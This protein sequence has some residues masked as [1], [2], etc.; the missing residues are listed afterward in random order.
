MLSTRYY[1]DKSSTPQMLGA[2]AEVLRTV[3]LA[4]SIH[5]VSSHT[6][7]AK[8][9]R[10]GTVTAKESRLAK[11]EVLPRQ[12]RCFATSKTR[13]LAVSHS[14]NFNGHSI[15]ATQTTKQHR[16]SLSEVKHSEFRHCSKSHCAYRD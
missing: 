9:G 2:K 3:L 12:I 8:I 1:I 10:Q 5:S 13:I 7:D 14:S 15:G 6:L 16:D 11:E 4:S